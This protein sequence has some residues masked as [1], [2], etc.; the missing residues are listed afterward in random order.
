MKSWK[1]RW[2]SELDG[3]VPQLRDDVKNAEIPVSDG[4]A[5]NGGNTAVLLKNKRVIVTVTAVFLAVLCVIVTCICVIKPKKQDIFMFT[6]EINPAVCIVSDGNGKVTGI[7][8]SNADADVVLSADGIGENIVGKSVDEAIVLYTDTAAKLGY[9]DFAGYGSAVR[10]SACG[11]G[12]AEELLVKS[13]AALKSYFSGKG[14]LAAVLT[15]SVS[16]EEF[17]AR[18]GISYGLTAEEVAN[19]VSSG[20]LLYADREAEGLDLGGLRNLYNENVLKGGL[21]DIVG[22]SLKENLDTLRKNFADIQRLFELYCEIY[23]HEDNPAMLLKDYWEVKKYYGNVLTGEFALLVKEMDSALAKY[24]EDYGVEITNYADL[25][26][27]VKS[28]ASLSVEQLAAFLEN[29]T[30]ELYVK[31]S[32]ELSEIL[33]ITGIIPDAVLS[34]LN[35]PESVEEYSYKI[36]TLLESKYSFR[37]KKYESVYSQN[38]EPI[39]ADEYGNFIS[40]I[41][42]KYGSLANYWN[43][44]KNS[45]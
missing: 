31:F 36:Q 11:D 41:E 30:Y 35:L 17:D 33:K 26:E 16:K 42:K 32:A 23:D 19:Y 25:L 8:S 1:N 43:N 29:F 5:A 12:N 13:D 6:V 28:Y 18:S 34:L 38:R 20:D 9:L 3:M 7:M 21:V 27:A 45:I 14:V 22:N 15:E 24:G 4:A 10:V 2:K 44:L 40:A 37:I 39:S